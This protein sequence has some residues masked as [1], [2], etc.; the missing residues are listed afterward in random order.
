[1]KVKDILKKVN[2]GTAK[3]PVY[4]QE[5]VSGTERKAV[6]F[7]FAD[8]YYDEKERTVTSISIGADRITV[9]YK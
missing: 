3:L 7:D 5:G 1:M 2:Y 9:H 4:L 8:Y 6:S